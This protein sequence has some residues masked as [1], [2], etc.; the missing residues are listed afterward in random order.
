MEKKVARLCWNTNRWTAP[1][2]KEGKSRSKIKNYEGENGYGHEEWLLDFSKVLLDGYHYAF[3]E[4]INLQSTKHVGKSYQIHLFAI[5][6]N[7]QR[8]YIGYIDNVECID[9]EAAEYAFDEYKRNKWFERQIEQLKKLGL[10]Y[11]NKPNPWFFNIRFKPKDAHI[12]P[13]FKVIEPDNPNVKGSHYNLMDL[14]CDFTFVSEN[15]NWIV[16]CNSGVFDLRSCLEENE[17]VDWKQHNYKYSIGDIVFILYKDKSR[18][19]E[20]KLQVVETDIT[21]EQYI[22]DRKYWVDVDECEEGLKQNR[23]VRFKLLETMPTENDMLTMEQ[24]EAHGL[25]GNVQ[26]HQKVTGKLLEYIN[27]A[28]VC[29]LDN[30]PDEVGGTSFFEG[31]KMSVTV[32]KYERDPKAREICLKAKGYS[33]SVCGM[34]FEDVYGKLGKHFI[35][36]HHLKPLSSNGE[37]ELDPVKDL[38]PVCPNCHA[39]LHRGMNGDAISVNELKKLM[40]H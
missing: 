37:Y 27:Q 22:N 8:R 12:E 9:G 4:E 29:T 1:S 3:L 34:N 38:I 24:L 20:F 18:K 26:G 31:A 16:P 40:K 5:D 6:G 13:F 23:Y 32:N 39:M 17:Y 10:K 11:A 36:V 33:C 28:F 25:K 35:H 15:T 21:S 7:K 2:G 30:N 19:I 14:K